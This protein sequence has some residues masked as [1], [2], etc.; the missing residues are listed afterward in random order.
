[1]VT[2]YTDIIR[3]AEAIS[4]LTIDELIETQSKV[5]DRYFGQQLETLVALEVL[6]GNGYVDD[7]WFG[8]TDDSHYIYR[9]DRWIVTRDPDGSRDLMTFDNEHEAQMYWRDV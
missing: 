9:I 3:E 8:Q 7:E 5:S 4:E 1:M 6:Q 2:P